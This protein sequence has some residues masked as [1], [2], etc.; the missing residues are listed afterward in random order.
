MKTFEEMYKDYRSREEYIKEVKDTPEYVE[1]RTKFEK[2]WEKHF[3][4]SRCLEA[5]KN[6]FLKKEYLYTKPFDWEIRTEQLKALLTKNGEWNDNMQSAYSEIKEKI[7][8]YN[9]TGLY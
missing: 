5:A 8:N 6:Y 2:E 1:K 3:S 9:E 4:D 7:K